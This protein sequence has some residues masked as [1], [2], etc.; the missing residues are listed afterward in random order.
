MAAL[1]VET[2]SRTGLVT[3]YSTSLGTTLAMNVARS[4]CA[5]AFGGAYGVLGERRPKSWRWLEIEAH[6]VLEGGRGTMEADTG[7]KSSRRESGTEY[8]R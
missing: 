2:D 4:G 1:S 7:S 5:L 8:F 6:E 3:E